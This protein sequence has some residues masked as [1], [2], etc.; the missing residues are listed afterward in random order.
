MQRLFQI[1]LDGDVITLFSRLPPV[2]AI[3]DEH[4]R[5]PWLW[6][7]EYRTVGGVSGPL[8]VVEHVKVPSSRFGS[9]GRCARCIV[10]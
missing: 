5:R 8:V 7:A 10:S 4:M 3:P 9:S 6:H 1:C 2:C